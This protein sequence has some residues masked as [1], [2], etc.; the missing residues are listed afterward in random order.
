MSSEVNN[1]EAAPAT[2]RPLLNSREPPLP[3]IA[4]EEKSTRDY[5]PSHDWGADLL[6]DR[7]ARIADAVWHIPGWL[8]PEDALKLYELAF[9]STG[10]ILEIGTYCGRSAVIL[11][12]AAADAARDARIVSL[13]VDPTCMVQARRA[14]E[15]HDVDQ[16]L[17]L[18]CA[19]AS[20]FFALAPAFSPT[21]VFVDGDHSADGVGTD[22]AALEG[23]IAPGGLLLFHDYLP[24]DIPDTSGF[25]ISAEPIEVAEVV[26]GSWVS[27]T[28]QFAGVFGRCGLFKL[29][30]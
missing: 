25:P 17:V 30:S 15:R 1:A 7:H 22:L 5:L 19:D 18:A 21:L 3:F 23:R 28:C 6:S 12:T 10:P 4:Y 26:S 27:D 29:V 8:D 24:R 14:A 16:H 11:A 20:S 13:D 9:L 2:P